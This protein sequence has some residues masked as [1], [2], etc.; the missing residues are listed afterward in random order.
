MGSEE[1]ER[2]VSQVEA[3]FADMTQK[4]E[5]A[6]KTSRTV[7]DHA[8]ATGQALEQAFTQ[9]LRGFLPKR[10]DILNG[11]VVD[12]RSFSKQQDVIVIDGHVAGPLWRDGDLGVVPI[13]AV[14]A[15]V[16]IKKNLTWEATGEAVDNIESVKRLARDVSAPKRPS[17][18]PPVPFGGVVGFTT[19]A[20]VTSTAVRRYGEKCAKVEDPNHRSDAMLIVGDLVMMPGCKPEPAKVALRYWHEAGG[21]GRQVYFEGTADP[22]LLFLYRLSEHVRRY[23]PPP[24]DLVRYAEQGAGTARWRAGEFTPDTPVEEADE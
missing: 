10:Y 16:E 19:D 3:A 12:G 2:A 24:L 13:E 6:F 1:Q 8:G 5:N 14:V 20:K 4:L 18:S 9:V 22:A 7:L 21:D 11:Q 23:Q 17:D 15:T